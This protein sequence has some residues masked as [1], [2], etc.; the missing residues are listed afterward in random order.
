MAAAIDP[1][2]TIG[3]EDHETSVPVAV[4]SDGTDRYRHL[5]V[6]ERTRQRPELL[7]RLGWKHFTLWTIEVFTDPSGCAEMIASELGLDTHADENGTAGFLASGTGHRHDGA[8]PSHDRTPGTAHRPVGPGT[9]SADSTKGNGADGTHE[10]K[11]VG[12]L[13]GTGHDRPGPGAAERSGDSGVP[14]PDV[15]GAGTSGRAP[16]GGTADARLRET[17]DS[18][19]ADAGV[20][21][22]ADDEGEATDPGGLRRPRGARRVTVAGTGPAEADGPETPA[23]PRREE[24]SGRRS[25]ERERDRW[26]KEQRP[27]HWG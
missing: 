23:A 8:R 3:R 11:G 19:D 18:D 7:E 22:D 4:E 26:L 21:A 9:S 10:N 24:P 15:S 20:V 25:A 1:V 16:A 17:D 13:T 2:L 6:R 5:S 14:G 12:A 27:P